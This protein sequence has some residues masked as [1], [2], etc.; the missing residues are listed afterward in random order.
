MKERKNK[1]TGSNNQ[2]Q[3][4]KKLRKQYRLP[5]HLASRV[6]NG[7]LTLKQAITKNREQQMSSHLMQKHGLSH[8]DAVQVARGKLDLQKAIFDTSF[9][10]HF[11]EY[12]FYS[13][14]QRS[15][16]EQLPVS[17]YLHNLEVVEGFV[18]EN[19]KYDIVVASSLSD[20]EERRGIHK[21]QIKACRLLSS[22]HMPKSLGDTPTSPIDHPKERFHIATKHLYT[23]HR[24]KANVQFTVLEGM[25]LEGMISW[26]GRFAFGLVDCREQEIVVYRHALS[27]YSLEE[28]ENAD[29]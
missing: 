9:R 6:A 2:R 4:S 27:G 28:S 22:Q 5:E 18:V 14:F 19:D 17:L 16:D 20:S 29:S 15:L 12:E 7:E 10:V 3:Q 23:L 25:A 8:S 11:K 13:I 24:Q 21:L 1:N 26:I